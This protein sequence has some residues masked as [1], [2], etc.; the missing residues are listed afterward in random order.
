[1]FVA[2]V[3][4]VIDQFWRVMARAVDEEVGLRIKEWV[5]PFYQQVGVLYEEVGLWNTNL[6]N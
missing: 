2:V 5:G 4:N 3:V 6:P 1:M